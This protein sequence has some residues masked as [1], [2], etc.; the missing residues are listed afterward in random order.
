MNKQLPFFL[1]LLPALGFA[2][3]A[4]EVFQAASP[5][6]VY[7]QTAVEIPSSAFPNLA[8]VTK[9]E[10]RAGHKIVNKVFALFTGSGFFIDTLGHVVTNNHVIS[11]DDEK[12]TRNKAAVNYAFFIEATLKSDDLK[13]EDKKELKKAFYD[14]ITKAP[15]V[16][17]LLVDNS[18]PYL[19]DVVATDPQL[20]LALL[21]T[22]A[23]GT[24]AL[25][26][27]GNDPGVGNDVFSLGYP[28]GSRLE[29]DFKDLKGSF[30][31]GAVSA[32]RFDN[33]GIQHTA[34]IN[35]GNS[36][37]P[38]LDTLGQ[39]VGV[40]V[41]VRTD[42]AN[43]YFAIAVTHV[44]SFLQDHGYN[45]KNLPLPKPT[46]AV[47]VKAFPGRNSLGEVEVSHNLI[48]N[49]EAGS[50]V[51]VNGKK[52]G[53]TPLFWKATAE[54][55]LL[56]IEG[57]TGYAE[58]RF[59]VLDNLTGSTEPA[60]DWK[61]FQGTLSLRA[62]PEDATIYIDGTSQGDGQVS[63]KVT[64]GSH[65]VEVR[66]VGFFFPAAIQKLEVSRDRDTSFVWHGELAWPVEFLGNGTR[67]VLTASRSG[68]DA[69]FDSKDD[70]LLPDGTW[71]LV[72]ADDDNYQAGEVTVTIAGQPGEV[73]AAGFLAQGTLLLTGWEQDATVVVDGRPLAQKADNRY[74]LP[75]GTH[76]VQVFQ[77]GWNPQTSPRLLITRDRVTNFPGVRVRSYSSYTGLTAWISGGLL[78][79]GL[80]GGITGY[81]LNADEMALAKTSSYSEYTSWKQQTG[82]LYGSGLTMA[83]LGAA[84][85]S[86]ALTMWLSAVN[87]LPPQ[88]R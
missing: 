8:A 3:T 28:L 36:G 40:N 34:T 24:P 29:W 62:F 38:L 27:S 78:V 73:D 21:E 52:I 75:V 11:L 7:I 48:F 70:F 6:V 23:K 9:L 32:V 42:A 20:D 86:L 83:S 77:A 72:W 49:Q 69:R 46:L 5:G 81:W 51:T 10:E 53:R 76:K 65:E 85:L 64:V 33:W 59:R 56:R 79:V 74:D 50:T 63:V 54:T 45:I 16:R 31:R 55:F 25:P 71:K 26:L 66:K 61:P 47:A 39:V 30:T 60:L 57:T 68:T 37:G 22:S 35:P 19:F 44:R 14:L 4:E 18:K 82:L 41:G 43:M 2:D 15:L 17:R 84:G 67:P 12:E 87:D 13:P 88:A 1:L 58:D 80:A